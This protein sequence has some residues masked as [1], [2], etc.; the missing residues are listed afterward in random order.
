MVYVMRKWEIYEVKEYDARV[1]S[2]LCPC[3][4][5]NDVESTSNEHGDQSPF[6]VSKPPRL[7]VISQLA[8]S[9][10]QRLLQQDQ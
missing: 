9:K 1:R 4:G 6:V 10:F 7:L 2:N 8:V 5:N 3:D